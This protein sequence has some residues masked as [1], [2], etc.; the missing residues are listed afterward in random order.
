MRTQI[1]AAMSPRNAVLKIN[2]DC[3]AVQI[4]VRAGMKSRFG[5]S[6]SA[7]RFVIGAAPEMREGEPATNERKEGTVM[8][9]EMAPPLDFAVAYRL[10]SNMMLSELVH[11][12][13]ARGSIK[14]EDVA[15]MLLRVEERAKTVDVAME[16]QGEVM[17][18]L[19]AIAGA[20]TEEW[21]SALALQPSL[22]ALRKRHKEWL[23]GGRWGKSPYEPERVVAYF[24]EDEEQ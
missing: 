7:R 6:I 13:M 24:A 8:E 2:K 5:M 4:D 11:A 3:A 20:T 19:E 12:L 17:P 10:Q 14:E 18:N 9:E 21:A 15:G 16:E 23:A 22:Y 1:S